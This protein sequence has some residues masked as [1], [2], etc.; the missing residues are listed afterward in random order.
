MRGWLASAFALLALGTVAFGLP[1]TAAGDEGPS[2]DVWQQVE[3]TPPSD[4]AG[5]RADVAPKR[6]KAY[7]LN[8]ARIRALLG[9][10]PRERA[11]GRTRGL[12]IALPA[13][14]GRLQRFELVESPVV[15]AGLA[16]AHPEIKTFSGTGI[17]DPDATLRADV[18]PIGFHPLVRSPKGSWYVDPYYHLDDSVYASYYTKD[19]PPDEAGTFVERDGDAEAVAADAAAADVPVGPEV[20][21][22]TYRL[23]LLS[24]PSYA[25]FF[26]GPANVTAAKV[27]LINRVDQIYEDE[28]A[29]RLVL[30]ADTEKTNLNTAADATGANG[31]CGAAPCFTAA[32]LASC[33]SGQGLGRNRIVLGQLVGA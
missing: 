3:G 22:R 6:F 29:I 10:A 31:P 30:I 25:T 18:T 12:V 7:R 19:V 17:D 9:Q 28:T 1:A 27:T 33:G 20:T 4:H 16:A 5:N 21:L 15:E 26:G 11:R 2:N 32:T 23:A 8:R 14:S 24:D 13:P